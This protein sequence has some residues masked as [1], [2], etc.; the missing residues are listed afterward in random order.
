[1]MKI[2]T[3]AYWGLGLPSAYVLGFVAGF[4]VT[5][6]WF[7]LVIGL[8]TAAVLLLHRFWGQAMPAFG[9]A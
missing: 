7:G 1:M 3:I 6:V 4:G 8:G 2:A 9:R 5:G